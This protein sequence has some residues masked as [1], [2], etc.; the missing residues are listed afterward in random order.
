[1]MSQYTTEKLNKRMIAWITAALLLLTLIPLPEVHAESEYG[2][3]GLQGTL[4]TGQG[5]KDYNNMKLV[6]PSDITV[7]HTTDNSGG[8]FLNQ[9]NETL[10]GTAGR[11][12]FALCMTAGMNQIG[13]A[14][15]WNFTKYN[16]NPDPSQYSGMSPDKKTQVNIYSLEPGDSYTGKDWAKNKEPIINYKKGNLFVDDNKTYGNASNG[17]GSGRITLYTEK[18]LESGDYI[19][20]FGA[21]TCGNNVEKVLGVPVAFQFKVKGKYTLDKA[22]TVAEELNESAVIGTQAGEYRDGTLKEALKSQLD[23]AKA[24]RNNENATLAQKEE[25]AQKL[26]DAI[27]ALQ[28]VRVVEATV[29]DII[30][31]PSKLSVGNYGTAKTSVTANPGSEGDYR[32]YVWSASDNID[33]DERTG[34][35]TA[36]W[37]NKAGEKS[38]ITATSK[39]H[40]DHPE[41]IPDG[42]KAASRAIEFEVTSAGDAFSVGIPKGNSDDTKGVLQTVIEKSGK[43]ESELNSIKKIKLFTVRGA[44]LS[45]KDF[46]YMREKLSALEEL[47]ISKCTVDA[48]PPMVCEGMNHLTTVKLPDR[49][50]KINTKAFDGCKALSNVQ[51]SAGVT[52]IGDNAFARCPSLNGKMITINAV[53]PPECSEYPGCFEGTSILGIKVPY[54]CGEAYRNHEYWKQFKIEEDEIE[55]T[56]SLRVSKTG[57]LQETAEAALNLENKSESQIDTLRIETSGNAV[58]DYS[59]DIP[60]LQ[61]NFLNAT[62]IDLSNAVLE[63]NRFKSSTFKDRVNLK[64]VRLN[65]DTTIIAGN[66]F[67]GC[68]NLRDIILPSALEKLGNGAFGECASLGSRIIINAKTPPQY[69]GAVF[70]DSITTILVP[71]G[72]VNAYKSALGWRQYKNNITS[73]IA[74]SL[75]AQTLSMEVAATKKLT[76][77][78]TVYNNNSKDVMWSSSNPQ[79]A[80]VDQNGN[81][82]G[83]KPGSAVI[84]AKTLEGLVKAKCTVTVNAPAAPAV[85]AVSAGYNKIKV[86]WTGISGAAGYEI[87]CYT[88]KNGSYTKKYTQS[89]SARSFTDTGKTTGTTYYY[90]VRAYKTNGNERYSGSYSSYAGAKPVLSKPTRVKAKKGGSKKIKVSWKKV[91]G[92][93]GY[94]IYRSTKKNKGY[95]SIK[96]VSSKTSKYT[97]SKL[98]KGKRYYYKVRAYRKIK[99]KKIY[100]AYSAAA[101]YKAR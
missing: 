16:L 62:T 20:E 96:S 95:K 23:E 75:S 86:T 58:L 101:S 98:K 53:T 76:A 11:I 59:D 39:W 26:S 89:A 22:I 29:N 66:A 83:I 69:D 97:N 7:L 100:S 49:L 48:L 88:K 56:L 25:M 77:N 55:D 17:D 81:V 82:K 3:Q 65:E 57:T 93:S 63:D 42:A 33:I 40:Q 5:I 1:M 41:S 71:P 47:D 37:A 28:A 90:R 21:E 4:Q 14:G 51:I 2:F 6:E 35:W 27:D 74:I 12:E 79:V 36:L 52:F 43:P 24:L 44:S 30:G 72:S 70:P 31:V 85:K 78:V 18:T 94:R 9:I 34:E 60:Y 84:T 46:T 19:L 50:S 64:K 91:S 13:E 8:Y 87:F 15:N 61:D 73:Q 67:S 68:R 99:G 80:S 32:K 38:H 45:D 92:A 54:G 10:D